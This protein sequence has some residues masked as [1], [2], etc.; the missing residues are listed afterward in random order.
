MAAV[1]IKTTSFAPA[2]Q[3]WLTRELEYMRRQG[4]D[5]EM[6]DWKEGDDT[7]ISCRCRSDNNASQEIFHYHIASAL[8]G[9]IQNQFEPIWIQRC[10]RRKKRWLNR[11]DQEKTADH[12]LASLRMAQA[13]GDGLPR[14]KILLDLMTY[15]DFHHTV[16]LEGFF[17]F[18]LQ[19]YQEQINSA[20]AESLQWLEDEKEHQEFVELL[21]YFVAMQ[22]PQVKVV[23]IFLYKSGLFRLL[24]EGKNAVENE[25]LEGFVADMVQGEINQGDLL[26]STMITLAPL[27]IHCHYEAK[28]PVVDTIKGVFEDR[29][30][31]CEGCDT[32][33]FRPQAKCNTIPHPG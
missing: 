21:R 13:D 9:A 27:R 5:V 14:H 3:E 16:H 12:A 20:I 26:M 15:L 18:R 22:E 19:A 4:L 25:Y 28:L 30:T 24:D 32:C 1:V 31:F 33:H 11:V 23:E 17:R 2:L 29:V 7:F 8:N 10:L 6:G